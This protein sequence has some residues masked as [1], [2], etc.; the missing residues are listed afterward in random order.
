VLGFGNRDPL[1]CVGG[2]HAGGSLLHH[3]AG[4]H[5]GQ[6]YGTLERSRGFGGHK[7]FLLIKHTNKCTV[8][9]KA[10]ESVKR[11]IQRKFFANLFIF[12]NEHSHTTHAS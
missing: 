1:A 9:F 2:E 10:S 7:A 6:T 5:L 12:K 3:A 8:K 4:L 11:E